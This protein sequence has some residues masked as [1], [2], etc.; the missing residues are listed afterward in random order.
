MAH[1]IND[2]QFA[3]LFTHGARWGDLEDGDGWGLN[4]LKCTFEEIMEDIRK[5]EKTIVC[6]KRN[7]LEFLRGKLDLRAKRLEAVKCVKRYTV[8]VTP[9]PRPPPRPRPQRCAGC[10]FSVHS[11]PPAHF[12]EEDKC[13]C[14]AYCRI[15]GGKKHGGSCERNRA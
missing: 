12:T 14:C 4:N 15:T 3:F 7:H 10:A 11:N 5:R 9:P 8:K 6:E 2:Q 1:A 13:H